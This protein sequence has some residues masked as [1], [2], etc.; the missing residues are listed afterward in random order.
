MYRP[1]VALPLVGCLTLASCTQ[2]PTQPGVTAAPP[3][4]TV[5]ALSGTEGNTCVRR[6]SGKRVCHLYV[7]LNNAGKLYVYP[8]LLTVTRGTAGDRERTLVWHSVDPRVE[9]AGTD[10]PL[11]LKTNPEFSNPTPTSD[12]EG[13]PDPTPSNKRRYRIT[14]LNTQQIPHDY[15]ISVTVSGTP[16]KCDPR[17]NN[18]GN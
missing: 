12:P 5:C 9:F 14:Y 6:P 18:S 2:T 4:P 16:M 15:N 11:E 17:I 3:S 13:D 8:H 1:I 7:G 10:G